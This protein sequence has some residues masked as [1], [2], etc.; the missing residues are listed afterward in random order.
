MSSALALAA[1]GG[2]LLYMLAQQRVDR[3]ELTVL[4]ALDHAI[5]AH[6]DPTREAYVDLRGENMLRGSRRGTTIFQTNPY[7]Y[8]ARTPEG[9]LYETSPVQWAEMTMQATT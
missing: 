2:L 1:G 9:D 7:T 4:R 5:L 8:Y 3:S 6:K